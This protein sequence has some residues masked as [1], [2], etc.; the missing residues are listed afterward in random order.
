[1]VKSVMVALRGVLDGLEL[2]G[3]GVSNKMELSSPNAIRPS[4]RRMAQFSEKCL[5]KNTPSSTTPFTKNY[6]V[7]YQNLRNC[8]LKTTKSFTNIYEIVYLD[9]RNRLIIKR[10]NFQ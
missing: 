10:L 6:E 2:D 3:V 5:A 7:V 4:A 9:K 1:M 8:V